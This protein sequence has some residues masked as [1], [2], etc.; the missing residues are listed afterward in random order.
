M[1]HELTLAAW[2]TNGESYSARKE[3]KGMLYHLHRC[4]ICGDA[5]DKQYYL[6]QPTL[7]YAND[8]NSVVF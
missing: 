1:G 6:L 8:N 5:S 7:P 2:M 4:V 3:N